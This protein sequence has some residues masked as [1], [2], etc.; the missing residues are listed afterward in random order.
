MSS[1]FSEPFIARNPLNLPN[2]ARFA[3]HKNNATFATPPAPL[4]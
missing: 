3:A 2:D 1:V 4:H